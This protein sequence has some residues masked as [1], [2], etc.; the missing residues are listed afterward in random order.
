[1]AHRQIR[2]LHLAESNGNNVLQCSL[3]QD[4]NLDDG[5]EYYALSYY[6]GA[7]SVMETILVD[8]IEV[9]I[10]KTVFRFLQQ[11]TYHFGSILVW[12]D[13]LCINQKDV[14]ERNWQ[15]STMGD[16]FKSAAGVYAWLGEGDGDCDYAISYAAQVDEPSSITKDFDENAVHEYF[17]HLLQRPYWTRVW[18]IQEVVLARRLWLLYGEKT[19]TWDS[20]AAA[21]QRLLRSVPS[22]DSFIPNLD[23]ERVSQLVEARNNRD[24]ERPDLLQY[25]QIFRDSRCTDARDKIYGLRGIAVDGDALRIDYTQ[26]VVGAFFDVLSLTRPLIEFSQYSSQEME[27][28]AAT[29]GVFE[30]SQALQRC[31]QMEACDVADACHDM[32]HDSLLG[33]L[34]YAGTVTESTPI[35]AARMKEVKVRG[36]YSAIVV[37]NTRESWYYGSQDVKIGDVVYE[38]KNPKARRAQDSALIYAFRTLD[39]HSKPIDLL[40]ENTDLVVYWPNPDASD[41]TV[42]I[43]PFEEKFGMTKEVFLAGLEVCRSNPAK[44]HIQQAQSN[45]LLVHLSRATLFAFLVQTEARISELDSYHPSLFESIFQES[46]THRLTLCKCSADVE[47]FINPN[48]E[49]RDQSRPRKNGES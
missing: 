13:A 26:S 21:L 9:Q 36:R 48:G 10:R 20:F 28:R 14:H 37:F 25:I 30:Y 19:I 43:V 29:S 4:C 40:C 47:V 1:M 32:K 24:K 23:W 49:R 12:L 3:R 22:E 44:A 34:T 27:E 15:V 45:I 2:L 31:I 11:L 6:W 46:P 35:H 38:L 39:P 41:P 7:P 42:D 17:G 8:G 18:V 16:L 33:C 5:I